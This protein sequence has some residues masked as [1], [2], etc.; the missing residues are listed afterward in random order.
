MPKPVVRKGF[1]KLLGIFRPATILMDRFKY[2]QKFILVTLVFMVPI[3]LL[4]YVFFAERNASVQLS[5]SEKNGLT[6][7]L[8]L[9]DVLLK[10]QE[11]R[12]LANGMLLDNGYFENQIEALD[13]QLNGAIGE[14][15][16]RFAASKDYP[17][18]QQE[19]QTLKEEWDSI[20]QSYAALTPSESNVLHTRWINSLF[21][22]STKF[23]D[24][25]N[26]SLDPEVASSYLV[27]TLTDTIPQLAEAISL[28]QSLTTG[29]IVSK[30]IST[31]DDENLIIH[32]DRIAGG[33]DNLRN[34]EQ[35][36]YRGEPGLETVLNE[37]FAAYIDIAERL[38]EYIKI[39][40]TSSVHDMDAMTLIEMERQS[41]QAQLEL[42]NAA[43]QELH[44]LLD[45]RMSADKTGAALTILVIIV[46]FSIAAY[47]FIGFYLGVRHA[48]SLLR[49]ASE[50]LAEGNLTVHANLKGKDELSE[51]G[52]AFDLMADKWRV[53]IRDN[54]QMASDL[55]EASEQLRMASQQ[56]AQSSD[57]ITHEMVESANMAETQLSGAEQSTRAMQEIAF[58]ISRIAE[59]SSS[60]AESSAE[61][62][63]RAHAGNEAIEQV[64]DQMSSISGTMDK[65]AVVVQEMGDKSRK[66]EEIVNVISEI[67]Q[68][69]Q[70]LSLNA[71]IEAARAG[72]HGR[73]FTVVAAEVKK[74][75]EQSSSSTVEIADIVR[76][77]LATVDDAIVSMKNSVQEVTKGRQ[78][79]GETGESFASIM[80][81]IEH[82][83]M[84][85]QEISAA[86][87]EISAGSEQVS[88]SL[89]EMLDITR[90]TTDITQSVSAAAE[91]QMASNEEISASS[92]SLQTMAARLQEDMNQFKV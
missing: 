36:I 12:S 8:L 55:A 83:N 4:F 37:P 2:A 49:E 52:A 11:H 56:A 90:K 3:C 32:I 20:K 38:G 26:L 87:E 25:T 84:Q 57:Q 75:A 72:E 46:F 91:Q 48:V 66:I 24:Q 73:G 53:I 29:L 67:S 41:I 64:S 61:A 44:N 43:S 10:A 86:A 34:V 21:A 81:A 76:D 58:G 71:S 16:H 69:T 40:R 60:A 92:E 79:A 47:L 9:N 54:Q 23:A 39:V 7:S 31:S 17:G 89:D 30:S 62:T 27:E 51:V 78:L 33:V 74:L 80:A 82:V 50:Q 13:E 85:V 35:A 18:L 22:F 77:I 19:W 68:Q 59:S 14:V 15:D 6:Y 65:L 70:L 42:R 1:L 5:I 88:A 28:S 63:H 45:S